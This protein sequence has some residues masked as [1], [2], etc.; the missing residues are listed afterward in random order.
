MEAKNPKSEEAKA[1]H[2]QEELKAETKNILL[3]PY[4]CINTHQNKR[5]LL[6]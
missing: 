1:R 2:S 5:A 4:S 3:L 6:C